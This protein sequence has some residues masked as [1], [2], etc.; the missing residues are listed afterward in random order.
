MGCKGNKIIHLILNNNKLSI[1]KLGI[2]GLMENLVWLVYLESMDLMD[3]KELR[4]VNTITLIL[5]RLLYM[6]V[7][8]FPR[9]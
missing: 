2:P 4:L 1:M 8:L 7:F 3:L 5:M 9:L 6:T